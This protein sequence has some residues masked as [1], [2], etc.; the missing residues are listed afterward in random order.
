MR[1][2]DFVARYGSKEFAIVL[3]DTTRPFAIDLAERSMTALRSLEIEYGEPEEPLLITVSV[4]FARAPA[5]RDHRRLYRT[6]RPRVD[7]AKNG[8]RDRTELDP[9]GLDE[10]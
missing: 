9:I 10:A 4:G 3:R 6:L 1:R 8:G 7:Q 5:R 2:G